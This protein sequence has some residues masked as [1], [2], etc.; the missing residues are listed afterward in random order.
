M[1]ALDSIGVDLYQRHTYLGDITEIIENKAKSFLEK[2]NLV[3]KDLDLMINAD[4]TY[5]CFEDQMLLG[6]RSS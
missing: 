6:F 4:R 3:L 1:Q 2:L 5:I